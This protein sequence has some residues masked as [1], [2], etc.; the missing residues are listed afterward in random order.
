M[1]PSRTCRL[2]VPV[3]MLALALGACNSSSSSTSATGNVPALSFRSAASSYELDN[4]YQTGAYALEVGSGNN[5]LSSEAS[6][7]TYNQSTGT[8]FVIGDG[9]TSIVEVDKTGVKKGSMVLSAGAFED[10]EGISW[11]SGNRFVLVEERL[12]QVDQFTYAAGTTLD[13][14]GAKIVKMGPTI[15]N[16]GLEGVSYD[17]KTTGYIFVKQMDPQGIFQS[18]VDFAGLTASNPAT[19]AAEST[20]LFDPALLDLPSKSINDVFALSNILDATAPDYD[21]LLIDDASDG[22]IVKVDRAGNIQSTLAMSRSAQNEG[23]TM[24]TDG[25]IYTVGEKGDGTGHPGMTVFAPT[26][27][28]TAV[29]AGSNLYLTFADNVTAGGGSITLKNDKG[30]VRTIPANDA[31]VTISGKVVKINPAW[32]M[33]PGTTYSITYDAGAFSGVEALADTSALSFKIVGSIDTTAPV[34]SSSAPVDDASNIGVAT[35]ITL[36][37]S[38]TVRAGTGFIVLESAG[39]TRNIDIT[40]TTQLAFSGSTITITPATPLQNGTAYDVKIAAGVITD[41]SFNAFAGISSATELNFTTVPLVVAAPT[42]LISEVNSNENSD[43]GADFFELYNYGTVDMDISGW[44]WSDNHATATD[45]NNYEVFPSNTVIPAGASLVVTNGTAVD[46][47][48]TF[49]AAW[50]LDVTTAVLSMGSHGIGLGKA[51]AVILFGSDG[52]VVTAL[53]Y[54]PDIPDATQGDGSK[55]AVPTSPAASGVGFVANSH[56]GAAFGGSNS[57]SAVW[58]GVSTTTPAYQAAIPGDKLGSVNT[59]GNAADIGSP[60]TTVVMPTVLISEVNSNENSANAADFFELY[61]YGAADVDISGWKWS[62]NNATATNS[63]KYEAF[64]ANTVIPA[65]KR[66]VVIND[67]DVATFKAAWGLDAGTTVLLMN[68]NGI[69]L[70]KGDAVVLFGANGKVV[71][72][73]NYQGSSLTA[74]QGDGSTTAVPASTKSDGTFTAGS[75]HAGVEFGGT[76]STSVV[77]DGISTAAPTYKAAAIGDALF[78]FAAPGNAA[79][80]GSPGK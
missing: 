8:L 32:D 65:G 20:N 23:V 77:W 60:G 44:K 35:P 79:D 45:A 64:P 52:K 78:S 69:G 72:A 62:D 76:A 41:T 13:A 63:A 19:T 54:G 61:N 47:A 56:A 71:A 16:I 40:D 55:V 1:K 27:D 22:R 9:G 70:G 5:L 73:L 29:G 34:L 25:N 12:R 26:K 75:N 48:A 51:D 46:D 50:G 37:F 59:P 17:P 14:A 33:A 49:K 4:Y 39:D 18:A 66:L 74:T 43:G 10:T 42:V 31:Q 28:K 53:N 38:E 36:D 2:L 24:D 3:S 21:S 80:I 15:G 30:D 11:V 68:G 67:A 58:D 6:G 7:V 57:T